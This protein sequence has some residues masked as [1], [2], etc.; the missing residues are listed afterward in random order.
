MQNNNNDNF[1]INSYG[2]DKKIYKQIVMI[3]FNNDKILSKQFLILLNNLTK[4]LQLKPQ[5]NNYIKYSS[6]EY[7]I[8]KFEN[9]LNYVMELILSKIVNNKQKNIYENI[10]EEDDISN[11]IFNAID[12]IIKGNFDDRTLFKFNNNDTKTKLVRNLKLIISKILHLLYEIQIKI[13][14]LLFEDKGNLES[15]INYLN[16]LSQ[17]LL[18]ENNPKIIQKLVNDLFI[19]IK[20]LN[21]KNIMNSSTKENNIIKNKLKNIIKNIEIAIIM[22][23][24][25]DYEKK[26]ISNILGEIGYKLTDIIN[27]NDISNLGKTITQ[28]KSNILKKFLFYSG[29]GVPSYLENLKLIYNDLVILIKTRPS[30]KLL[31]RARRQ[32]IQL[33]DSF[34]NLVGI[35]QKSFIEFIINWDLVEKEQLYQSIIEDEMDDHLYS[36][37]KTGIV[38][39]KRQVTGKET[40]RKTRKNSVSKYNEN[41]KRHMLSK[42][43]IIN[44]DKDIEDNNI[45]NENFSI[46]KDSEIKYYKNTLKIKKQNDVC[47]NSINIYEKN[48]IYFKN[49]VR[50]LIFNRF[51]NNLFIGI[52]NIE[53]DDN[54]SFKIYSISQNLEKGKEE[55]KNIEVILLNPIYI[56]FI[57]FIIYYLLLYRQLEIKK[58]LKKQIFLEI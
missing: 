44:K 14:L 30:E 21:I 4:L 34:Y 20:L 40:P 31:I 48:L 32:Y 23:F 16:L 18:C 39:N 26:T 52:K 50:K 38:L 54:N 5:S 53:R 6:S 57:I 49:T 58:L 17:A 41:N 37:E 8:F 43:N 11:N 12:L 22:N 46:D 28:I 7:L 24:N 10:D 27:F 9:D 1:N 2:K 55:T 3:L 15:K 19:F 36:E 35:P 45:E 51:I 33:S 47:L 25:A 29:I 56:V 42:K 13:N